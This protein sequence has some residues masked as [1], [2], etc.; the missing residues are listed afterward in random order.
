MNIKPLTCKIYH[1]IAEVTINMTVNITLQYIRDFAS[2]TLRTWSHHLMPWGQTY[3][4]V[5]WCTHITECCYYS[6][7]LHCFE[8]LLFICPCRYNVHYIWSYIPSKFQ[9]DK[10]FVISDLEQYF[11]NTLQVQSSIYKLN[12]ITIQYD[13]VIIKYDY[14]FF[15]NYLS[16]KMHQCIMTSMFHPS[17]GNKL[18]IL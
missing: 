4:A 17:E 9:P 10:K 1:T 12:Y 8:K 5:H 15:L 14:V 7:L 16:C 11:V 6:M 3:V 2:W 18:Y 13:S